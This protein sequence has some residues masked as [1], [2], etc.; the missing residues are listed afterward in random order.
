[1]SQVN[2]AV[3]ARRSARISRHHESIKQTCSSNNS[4]HVISPTGWLPE[5]VTARTT[6]N[7]IR[8]FLQMEI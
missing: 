6:T 2:T 4:P 8:G 3:Y 5:E 7:A 1:M